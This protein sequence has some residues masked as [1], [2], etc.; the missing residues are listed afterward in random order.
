[1]LPKEDVEKV[2]EYV[3]F[4]KKKYNSDGSLKEKK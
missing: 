1:V 2:E 3:E 4:L